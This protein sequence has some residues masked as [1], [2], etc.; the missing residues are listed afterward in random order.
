MENNSKEFGARITVQ[1]KSKIS[2]LIILICLTLLSAINAH[3]EGGNASTQDVIIKADEMFQNQADQTVIAT[4][5]V[6]IVYSGMTMTADK[7]TYNRATGMLKATGKLTIS[8][9]EETLRGESA[10][11]D[12]QSGRGEIDNGTLIIPQ[13]NA[14]ITSKK[15]IREDELHLSM[16]ENELTTCELPDPSWKFGA[17]KL[18]VNLL[19]YATGRNIIFYVKDV[20]VLY[21]PWIAFP[22]VKDKKSGLLP[23]RL[24]YAKSRGFQLDI[25][26]YLVIAPNQDITIDFDIL[27]KRGMGLGANYRYIRKRGSEG[28]VG[29]YIIYDALTSNWRGQF[30][31]NHKEIFSSDMNLRSA[32]NITSDRTFISD[33][34]LKIGDYNRQSDVSTVNFLKTWQHYAFTSNLRYTQNYY[35]ASNSNTLQTLPD[36]GLAAVRQ[37]VFATPLYFD[38]DAVATNFYRENGTTG[39]RLDTFPRLTLITGKAGYVN[40][41]AYAGLHMLGYNTTKNGSANTI[42]QNDGFTQPETGARIS[43][44]LS[45]VY[46][47]GGGNLKKLRHEIVPEIS[48]RYAP[49]RDQSRLPFY[50]YNDRLLHQNVIYYGLTSHLGGKFQKNDTVEYR[51]LSRMK[52][53]QGYSFNGT[54]RDLLSLVETNRPMSD[55]MLETETWFNPRTSLTFDARYNVYD[56][57]ISSA[58]PGIEYSDPDGNTAAVSYSMSRNSLIP[59]NQIEY[60]Q[61]RLSTKMFKPWTFGYMTRYS[62]DKGGF[63]ETVYSTEYRHQCW[64]IIAA[65]HD[66]AGNPSFTFSFN[67]MGLSTSSTTPVIQ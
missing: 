65:F 3:A 34:S 40:F 20:P 23:P 32:I 44:S 58:S 4:G 37:Q 59:A 63:L 51:N 42:N 13:S 61:A 6:I 35:A 48:Y 2:N 47:L 52:L 43:T 46:E 49:D 60:M 21:L 38:L 12:I 7:A 28:T 39:Q 18:N 26:L 62:F 9:G 45:K 50:D 36:I 15:I 10:T 16:S 64:S 8:K 5:N 54:R 27:T 31:E 56:N 33:Y 67:L 66:R 17:E 57:R 24:G 53:T 55:I 11:L 14:T 29:G 22:V 30:V 41:S 19:G 25:P 1:I